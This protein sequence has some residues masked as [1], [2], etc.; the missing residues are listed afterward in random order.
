MAR[1]IRAVTPAEDSRYT[2][3]LC[4][5]ISPSERPFYVDARP[6]MGEPVNECFHVVNR[7]IEKFGGVAVFGWAIWELPTVC[8]EAEFHAVWKS[9]NGGHLDVAPKSTPTQR[10]FFL[11][12][13]GRAYEGYPLDNV[14]R[15][16]SSAPEVQSFFRALEAK[17]EL[18]NRGCRAREHG[19]IRL[20][21]AEAMEYRQIEDAIGMIGLQV[22][23]LYPTVGPYMPCPCGS[24]KKSKWCHRL[25]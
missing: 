14:R 2:A 13:P 16:I 5:E 8:V 1:Y 4:A 6:N 25:E 7:H 9:P 10:V 20:R 23:A 24:G 11:P 12:D 22:H 3:S 19:E 15:P 17:Y 21:G 18:M